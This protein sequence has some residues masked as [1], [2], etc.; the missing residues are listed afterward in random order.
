MK[1]LLRKRDEMDPVEFEHAMTRFRGAAPAD[2]GRH[3]GGYRQ[4]DADR[5][6]FDGT[7]VSVSVQEGDR[8]RRTIRSASSPTRARRSSAV[9]LSE[10]RSEQGGASAWKCRSTSAMSASCKGKSRSCRART[11]NNGR[12][13]RREH[14]MRLDQYLLVDV[15]DKLPT[16]VERGTPL[17]A[18]VILDRRAE[19]RRHPAGRASHDRRAALTCKWSRRTGQSGRW[20]WKSGS[21]RRRMRKSCKD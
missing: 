15:P 1:K 19:R 2:A 12:Q 14:P 6:E 13:A 4:G 8:S 7:V 21:R 20:T 10:G 11:K 17:S 9:T 3:G 16:D 5:A 18:S